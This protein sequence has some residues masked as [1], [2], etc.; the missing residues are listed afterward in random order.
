MEE[1]ERSQLEL[2]ST[3]SSRNKIRPEAKFQKVVTSKILSQMRK[4][5]RIISKDPQT[6]LERLVQEQTRPDQVNTDLFTSLL[7][8][9]SKDSATDH[10]QTAVKNLERKSKQAK[11]RTLL[12]NLGSNSG[13]QGPDW[14]TESTNSD[15]SADNVDKTLDHFLDEIR[16]A[17]VETI[18]EWLE[19]KAG[20][21]DSDL[22]FG[23][24]G[25]GL[26]MPTKDFSN[27]TSSTLI[28]FIKS[29]TD[30]FFLLDAEYHAKLEELMEK[31]KENLRE[32]Q[33]TDW[34]AKDSAILFHLMCML[35][36]DSH[37]AG[38]RLSSEKLCTD[39]ALRIFP[40]YSREQVITQKYRLKVKRALE[41]KQE[42]IIKDW[43]RD[44]EKL[45]KKINGAWDDIRRKETKLNELEGEKRL[46]KEKCL[47]WMTKL[48]QLQ[49]SNQ[50]KIRTIDTLVKPM[51]EQMK[52]N[53]MSKE[54]Q[55][56][57]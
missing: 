48:E 16:M 56:N 42:S 12:L 43:K 40:S 27:I 35:Q 41:E 13:I 32:L 15:E 50:K 8:S 37:K 30:Q 17:N 25:Y 38:S 11:N 7:S 31:S 4:D 9:L 10:Y 24:S 20:I 21:N 14:E 55:E 53:T 47:Y 26:K 28:E 44:K 52:Q 34:S 29:A 57:R 1:F 51:E 19:R 22:P 18:V 6:F 45:V 2:Q 39:V 49:L 36:S 46:Q 3:I 33:R 23:Q 54:K 5:S